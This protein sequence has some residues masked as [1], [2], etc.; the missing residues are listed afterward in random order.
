MRQ[1]R[2]GQ[3]EAAGNK[4]N[5]GT[6]RQLIAAVMD[7]ADKHRQQASEHAIE[8]SRRESAEVVSLQ[9]IGTE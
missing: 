6:A 7:G 5:R 8:W 9:R 4:P 2:T 3:G 1:N